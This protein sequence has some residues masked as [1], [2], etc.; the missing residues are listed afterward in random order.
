MNDG[1]H[2]MSL[3]VHVSAGMTAVLLGGL[4]LVR[5]KGGPTHRATGRRF[6]LA[7]GGVV[8]SAAVGL[9]WVRW[10]PLLAILAVLVSYLTLGGWRAAHFRAKGPAA[11]DAVATI[12]GV[13][14][15]G[16]VSG[17]LFGDPR[18]YRGGVVVW[19]ALAGVVAVLS[20]DAVR[21]MLPRSAWQRL[22]LWE[23]IYKC[24]AALSAMV[25]AFSGNVVPFG[26]PWSQL[27][28][29]V[30]AAAVTVYWWRRTRK[31]R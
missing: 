22:W 5:V 9:T 6:I 16:V 2:W 21:W 30:G 15:A 3:S 13:S 26:Q 1:M 7:V 18:P 10:D 11:V 14:T 12:V 29:S 4:Q 24:V 27:G 31:G 28:P 25:S 19:A 20:Y 8:A 23:H 17:G